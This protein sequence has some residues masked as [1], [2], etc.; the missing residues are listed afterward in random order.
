VF[1]GAINRRKLIERL[2]TRPFLPVPLRAL[3]E[4]V[5]GEADGGRNKLALLVTQCRK[6]VQRLVQSG[7]IGPIDAD[8]LIQYADDGYVLNARVVRAQG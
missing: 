7:S 8:S 5:Y 1:T 4:A 6:E 3:N 2:A